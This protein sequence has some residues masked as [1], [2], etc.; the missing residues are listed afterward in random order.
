MKLRIPEYIALPWLNESYVRENG[1]VPD[2]QHSLDDMAGS[3]IRFARTA[4]G[5]MPCMPRT[6]IT[7]G[8]IVIHDC[9]TE[10]FIKGEFSTDRFYRITEDDIQEWLDGKRDLLPVGVVVHPP[11]EYLR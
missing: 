8:D 7:P 4:F 10:R 11:A 2:I 1:F 9:F 5:D 3:N 6:E